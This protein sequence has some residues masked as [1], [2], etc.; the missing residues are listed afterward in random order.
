MGERRGH[1]AVEVEELL[2]VWREA[3][4]VLEMLPSAAP[5]RVLVEAEIVD[6]KRTYRRLTDGRVESSSATL[7][8]SAELIHRTRLLLNRV[9]G[10]HLQER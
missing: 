8:R 9:E 4:R 10:K 5:D 6:L 1:V 2:A 3:E 7:Q